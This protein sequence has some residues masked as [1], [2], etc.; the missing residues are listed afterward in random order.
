M[1]STNRYHALLEKVFFD[2]YS[3]GKTE[4][5][6]ARRD[7]EHAAVALGVALPKN[8]G[9]VIYSIRYRSP[10]PQS[11]LATQPT[12]MEWVIAGAGRA[13]YAFRLVRINR[14]LPRTDMI[15]IKI[16]DATPQ[17]IQ[18]YAITDEQALLAKVRYNRLID[19]FLGLVAYSLQ[20][21]LRTTVKGIG[22]IEIDEIYVGVDRFG[23]QFIIPVQAKGGNDQLSVIQTEQDILCCAQKYPN[24]I[25][26]AISAQFFGLD[27]IALFELTLDDG[28]VKLVEERHYRLLPSGEITPQDLKS[29][30]AR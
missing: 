30:S 6:W 2:L 26:R 4:L 20:N 16:P 13:L 9:D 29:Y 27:R 17:I 19:L 28:A 18:A 12:G 10:M 24:L 7:F 5:S 23:R 3:A 22:Q 25:V 21:H 8:L 15:T 1:A 14:I 11:I